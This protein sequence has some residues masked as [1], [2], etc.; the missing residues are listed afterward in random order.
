MTFIKYIVLKILLKNKQLSVPN[1]SR[2]VCEFSSVTLGQTN[3]SF[4]D[5]ILES[6]GIFND[7]FTERNSW[8]RYANV[9]R[10]RGLGT[11]EFQREAGERKIVSGVHQRRPSGAYH[12][13][14]RSR[15][16]Q[17]NNRVHSRERSRQMQ[18]CGFAENK[19]YTTCHVVVIVGH[20]FLRCWPLR[21]KRQLRLWEVQMKLI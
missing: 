18:L 5:I 2:H 1:E 17:R 3:H 4:I 15:T 6:F 20:A 11:L 19:R 16:R 14:N 13:R 8:Q 10:F 12:T 21:Q 7:L 9:I